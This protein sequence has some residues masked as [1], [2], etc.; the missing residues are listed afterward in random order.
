MAL[1][2]F[3]FKKQ[4]ADES[5]AVNRWVCENFREIL[6]QHDGKHIV[7]SFQQATVTYRHVIS[8]RD[9]GRS[10]PAGYLDARTRT[11]PAKAQGQVLAPIVAALSSL[12]FFDGL[13]ILP[14][15]ASHSAL[16]IV[17]RAD[18]TRIY[19]S[20]C[21]CDGF[22]VRR[23]PIE[24]SFLAVFQALSRFCDFPSLPGQGR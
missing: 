12:P 18:G 17:T 3:L 22:S 6:V 15:G 8:S 16:M 10:F 7:Y 13:E 20:N 1:F 9:G 24:P 11:L 21:H 4:N 2:D 23:D 19:Y 14:P 5:A